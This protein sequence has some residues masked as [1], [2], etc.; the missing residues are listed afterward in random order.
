[1]KHAITSGTL[2]L[3]A[4][5]AAAGSPAMAQTTG[6]YGGLNLGQSRAKIDDKRITSSLISSGFAVTGIRDDDRDTGG[7]LFAGYQMNRN[8]ALE[9]GYFDLGKFGFTANTLPA[10]AL[11]GR[12]KLRGFNLDLV[13]RLPVT[14][15]L[16][17]FARVGV[18]RAEAR[19][20]FT[21]SGSVFVR[22]PSPSKRD[23]NAKFGVGLEYA[24]TEA[25]SMRLEA[26][27]YRINDAV[28]NNGDVDLVSLG[29]I[30]RFGTHR[31][32]P[33]SYATP[34][35]PARE[36]IAVA[37]A[38]VIAPATA[39]VPATPVAPAPARFE[40]LTLSATELFGFDSARL[41][42]PQPK[43]DEIARVLVA[44]RDIDN[45]TIT[46][47]TDRIGSREYNQNLSE[48]RAKSVR[49]YLISQSVDARRLTAVGK[50]E[51]NPVVQCTNKSRPALI[52]CLAPNRRVEVEQ[53]T[54]SRR[55]Q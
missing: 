31:H 30:Y 9:G 19:D 4:M 15:K 33:V 27:R 39:V 43:L 26:E 48:R 11:D 53:I 55:V 21:G 3:A 20:T 7:K 23:T 40:K 52:A 32:T 1:M 50:S 38:P 36:I 35:E 12:I 45:V 8:F 54:V 17:A 25:V 22:N 5:I 28:G 16:S 47:Y 10:G 18:N 49:N 24:F 51:D 44:N 6:W 34:P 2:A 13:G 37:P 14:D 42:M 46:G 41:S 29:V